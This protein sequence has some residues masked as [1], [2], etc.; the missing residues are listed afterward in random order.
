M[1]TYIKN[2]EASSKGSY[3]FI[4]VNLNIMIIIIIIIKWIIMH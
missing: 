4:W 1:E 3:W 2:R